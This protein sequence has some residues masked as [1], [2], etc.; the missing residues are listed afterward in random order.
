MINLKNSNVAFGLLVS[1]IATAISIIFL[2]SQATGRI[3]QEYFN[4]FF[5]IVVGVTIFLW[6]FVF[7]ETKP[8]VN[9]VMGFNE[10]VPESKLSKLPLIFKLLGIGGAL[11]LLFSAGAVGLGSAIIDLPQPFTQQSLAL[12]SD[13]EKIFYQSFVPGFFEEAAIYI[14]Y[15]VLLFVTVEITGMKALMLKRGATGAIVAGALTY[16][17]IRAYGSDTA[18]YIGIFSFESIVQFFNIY[19]GAF[20]SWIP[21][22]IHNIVVTLNFLSVFSVGGVL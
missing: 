15:K 16:F 17:H 20:L 2:F 13:G 22:I 11:A 1:S 14:L 5:P 7:L 8:K 9:S 4:V 21:H 3:T 6:L 19:T 10:P 18:A 12:I